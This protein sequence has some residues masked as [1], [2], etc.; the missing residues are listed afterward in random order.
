MT[1]GRLIV[2]AAVALLAIA[3]C[4][5]K[6]GAGAP[7]SSAAP[8]G[9]AANLNSPPQVEGAPQI[10]TEPDGV[11]IEY[12]T[13]GHGEPAVVLV[14][15]WATDA[16]YWS[17]Q[18]DPLKAKYTVVAIDLA[19]HGASTKNRT[20]WSMGNYGEDVATVVRQIQNRQ[21]VI[22]GHSMGG[23]VA[24]EAARRIGDR[25]IGIV[26]VDALKSIGLPPLPP[27]EIEK[28][29]AP[30]RADFIG[31]TRKYV[32]ESLFAA[33]ADPVFVQKVAYDMS[34]EPPEVA[35][36]SLQALLS[37][38]F[39]SVL[40]GIHVPVLAINSDLTP[41]DEARI[42]RFLPDFKADVL[43]HT[44]HFLMME[45]PQT[46]NPILLRDIDTLVRRATH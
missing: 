38:D 26:V 2:L 45:A 4:S 46:F 31:Q 23:T 29:V 27:N 8:D 39:A 33:G 6:T 21:V 5:G 12:R 41:T 1:H 40:P 3:A 7:G 16:N 36:P 19:G 32:T 10:A 35:V 37:M 22:V 34:L 25:I 43:P 14:H 13:Y 17:A 9:A 30:F 18:L 42:R 15:G 44:G 20:D 28:R 24:L 11:H